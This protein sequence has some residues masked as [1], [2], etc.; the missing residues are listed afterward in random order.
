MM[1]RIGSRGPAPTPTS[2]KK[3]YGVNVQLSNEPQP[4]QTIPE[5]PKHIE[6]DTVASKEWDR[7]VKVLFP[8]GLITAID[9]NTLANYCL[10]HSQVVAA[11]DVLSKSTIMIIGYRGGFVRN[12]AVVVMN[13]AIAEMLKLEKE[14]GMTPSS[15]TRITVSPN[16][17]NSAGSDIFGG[18]KMPEVVELTENKKEEEILEEEDE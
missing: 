16:P 12:P 4:E 8:L 15:R 6:N 1:N 10:L 9:G 18:M 13:G 2:L 11:A 3:K 5:K 7:L 14:F 17:N